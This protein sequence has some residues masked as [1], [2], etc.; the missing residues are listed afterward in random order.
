MIPPISHIPF[1]GERRQLRHRLDS[2]VKIA[3]LIPG[4]GN[5]IIDLRGFAAN[6][7]HRP[8]GHPFLVIDFDGIVAD[9]QIRSALSVNAFTSVRRARPITGPVL[10]ALSRKP[11]AW[12][13][14]T[15]GIFVFRQIEAAVLRFYCG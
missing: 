15:K 6:M 3:G 13:V 5:L 7:N 10:M 8:I 1:V 11:L 2:L 12:S 4:E 14:V 9:R